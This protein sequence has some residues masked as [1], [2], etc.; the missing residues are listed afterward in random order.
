MPC[1]ALKKLAHVAMKYQSEKPKIELTIT[2]LP[3]NGKWMVFQ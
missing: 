2:T 3:A 1:I